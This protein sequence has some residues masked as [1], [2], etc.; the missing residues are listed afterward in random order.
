M[1]ILGN[2]NV[3]LTFG[4]DGRVCFIET[5]GVNALR[6]KSTCFS[7]QV[8]GK[9]ILGDS[10][11]FDGF[12]ESDNSLCASYRAPGLIVRVHFIRHDEC[13]CIEIRA[14][15]EAEANYVGTLEWF[16]FNFPGIAF[17][18]P[19]SDIFHAPGQGACHEITSKNINFPPRCSVSY[20]SRFKTEEDMFSTTPDKGAGL[21]AVESPDGECI[22]FAPYSEEEN[23]FPMTEVLPSGLTIMD[24]NMIVAD[25]ARFSPMET[26]SVFIFGGAYNSILSDYQACLAGLLGLKAPSCPDWCRKSSI[27]EVHFTHL[28]DFKKGISML[29]AIKEDGV[30]TIYLMPCFSYKDNMRNGVY[31]HGYRESGAIYSILD[32]YQVD[33]R[34]GGTGALKDFVDKAHE[35]GMHVIL[36]FIPQGASPYGSLFKEHPEWFER[37]KDGS[38]FASHGWHNTYSLNWAN[39]EVSKFF[40]EMGLY[41]LKELNVDGFR[42]DAPHWK[43]P[44]MSKDL[45]Y[46][47][48]HVCYGALRMIREF[49][50]KALKVKSDVLFLG[51]IWGAAYEDCTTVQCEY[52]IHWALYNAATGFFTG[53]NLQSWLN[54]YRY[55]QVPGSEKAVFLETHDTELLTPVAKRLRGSLVSELISWIYVYC[56]FIPMIWYEELERDRGF[57]RK[58]NEVRKVL[59]YPSWWDISYKDISSDDDEVFIASERKSKT[60]MLANFS[61]K[62]AHIR[63]SVD[64]AEAYIDPEKTY[65]LY[66]Y[67]T[68]TVFPLHRKDSDGMITVYRSFSGSEFDGLLIDLFSFQSCVLAIKE[69]NK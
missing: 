42:I 28:G 58:Q 57:I 63:L 10:M 2:N 41:Y 44:D 40:I 22:A 51:E 8:D 23:F 61:R 7:F 34:A 1:K 27:L 49:H 12:S 60:M 14:A 68:G 13:K 16:S 52:N 39:P 15:I 53:R 19:E 21:L 4:D 24:R 26:G 9:E 18:S 25:L 29:P 31:I 33:E 43:E 54:E 69:L 20:L 17:S 48:S 37:D 11:S 5:N 6:K 67:V 3:R 62:M 36:D 64:N 50:A 30:G 65:E 35:M 32:Y 38:F 46:H 56:G 55:T 45:E 47:A 66:D 59:G